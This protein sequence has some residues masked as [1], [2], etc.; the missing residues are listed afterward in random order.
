MVVASKQ[1]PA[2]GVKTISEVQ[3]VAMAAHVAPEI[4]FG[5]SRNLGYLHN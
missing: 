4:A 2:S 1:Q 3:A 5:T